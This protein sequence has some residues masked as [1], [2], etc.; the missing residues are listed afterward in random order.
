M[1]VRRNLAYR[2]GLA[3]DRERTAEEF[4]GAAPDAER[5]LG[6]G[7]P[8]APT[9]RVDLAFWRGLPGGPATA[10]AGPAALQP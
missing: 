4:A 3:G 9:Y 5:A 1:S 2:R 6:A 7:R 8:T 10:P